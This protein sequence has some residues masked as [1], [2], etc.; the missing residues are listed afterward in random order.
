MT[1][2]NNVV[3]AELRVHSP[4]ESDRFVG[5]SQQEPNFSRTVFIHNN[6]CQI[7]ALIAEIV[8]QSRCS[9]SGDDVWLKTLPQHF[10]EV[11]NFVW[12]EKAQRCSRPVFPIT[13]AVQLLCWSKTTLILKWEYSLI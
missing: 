12:T 10:V 5:A 7:K 4:C 9:G 2:K 8:S 3:H 1:P 6:K 11:V 13:V